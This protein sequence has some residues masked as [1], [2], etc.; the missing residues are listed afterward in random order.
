MLAI[1]VRIGQRIGIHDECLNRKCAALEAEMRR[2]LWW[3]LV[4]Y[5]RRVCEMSDHK[6]STLDPTWDCCLPLN[7]SDFEV[8]SSTGAKSPVEIHINVEFG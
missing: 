3:S 8:S 5:D 1:A 6:T 2:R 4:L 7:I